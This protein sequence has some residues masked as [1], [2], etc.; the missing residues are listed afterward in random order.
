MIW[1][2]RF[3][4]S[5][6]YCGFAVCAIAFYLDMLRGEIGLALLMLLG[7]VINA[8]SVASN[9]NSLEHEN[10]VAKLRKEW[11]AQWRGPG[12]IEGAKK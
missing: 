11:E 7:L 1:L 10:F 12:K 3:M 5:C 4:V 8:A 9:T 6:Y 2:I